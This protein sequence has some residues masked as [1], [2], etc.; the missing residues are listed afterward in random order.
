MT[1]GFI[2]NQIIK[3]SNCLIAISWNQED[4]S[5]PIF[6]FLSKDQVADQDGFKR[7]QLLSASSAFEDIFLYLEET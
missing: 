5:L 1:V 6:V 2:K 7:L 4:V 3:V